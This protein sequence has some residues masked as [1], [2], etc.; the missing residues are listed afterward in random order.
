[1]TKYRIKWS[2]VSALA[3]NMCAW[4][5]ILTPVLFGL[6]VVADDLDLMQ[7][8]TEEQRVCIQIDQ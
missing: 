6:R 8:Q 7:Q 1:M 4:V 5:I 2:V 3:L